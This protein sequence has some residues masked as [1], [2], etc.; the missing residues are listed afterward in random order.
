MPE[1]IINDSNFDIH[2]FS[3]QGGLVPR[4]F[5]THPVGYVACAKPFDLPLIPE[6]EWQ[7]RLDAL[8][9]SGMLLS[10]IRAKG[11]AGQPIPS[12]DQDSIGYCWCHSP[13]SAC[14]LMRAVAN[15][16]YED[17]SPF[18]IGCMIK[19]FQ[20]QGGWNAE[21]VEFMGTRG[22]PTSQFWPQRSMSR[23]NDNPA[24]WENAKK[25]RY[26]EWMDLDPRNMKAQ[27]VTC[28][29]MGMA[30]AT[31]HN[32]WAHSICTC[33]LVSLTPFRTR[34][35]NSWGDSWSEN[36]MGILQGSRAIPDAAIACRVVTAAI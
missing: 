34:I 17:L 33:D 14:L 6:S 10:Q 28:L 13:V 30:L 2:M 18:A 24:T 15:E 21:A 31:D 8:N 35:W 4:N 9:A 12:R 1:I 26:L 16:P 27:M 23:P 7:S 11:N 22:C 20:D 3:G 19:G 29:L 32:W 25:Y 36:G 5:T